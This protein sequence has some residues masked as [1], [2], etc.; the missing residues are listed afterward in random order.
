MDS[1]T[2]PI[3]PALADAL[4]ALDARVH[5]ARASL[6]EATR[7]CDTLDRHGD[8]QERAAARTDRHRAW[9][10]LTEAQECLATVERC[11]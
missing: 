10:R 7:R 4:V 8:P 5:T 2:T 6:D 9:A 1:L 11:R 3:A